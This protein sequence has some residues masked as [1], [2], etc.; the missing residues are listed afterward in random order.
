MTESKTY[1]TFL[2]QLVRKISSTLMLVLGIGVFY[3]IIM[4]FIDHTYYPIAYIILFLAILKTGVIANISLKKVSKLINDCHSLNNMILTFSFIILITLFSFATDYTCLYQSNSESFYGLETNSN[5]YL[6]NLF[7]FFYFS[8]TTFST[9]GFGDIN[10]VS[11]VA[12]FIVMLEIF[13]S[14]LIIV[15]SITSIKKIHINE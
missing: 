11:D 13:L 15:F 10:P 8:V 1:R 9:V 12:K 3:L 7:Q 14:F 5:S 4:S 6:Y 2:N